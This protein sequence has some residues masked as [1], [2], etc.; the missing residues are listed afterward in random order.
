MEVRFTACHYSDPAHWS[1]ATL[2]GMSAV[3]T[4]APQLCK[5]AD[6]LQKMG[7]TSS[8]A[9]LSGVCCM[10]TSAALSKR[11]SPRTAKSRGGRPT[12]HAAFERD[13]R[14]LDAAAQLFL[15]RGYDATSIDSVAE[16]ARVSKPTVYSQY[17]DKRGLFEAV[18]KREI[19]RWL[20]PVAAAVQM[21]FGGR[22]NASLEKRLYDLG[23]QL[24]ALSNGAGARAVGRTL[25]AQSTNF[26]E[27]AELAYREGWEKTVANVAQLFDQLGDNGLAAIDTRIAA[28]MYLNVVIGQTTRLALHGLPIDIDAEEKR[29]R[30]SL[31]LLLKGI[32]Q[33]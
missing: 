2:P 17:H 8:F 20:A 9:P 18:L 25:A 33:T 22:A 3:A 12:K 10:V 7:L 23:R 28:E 5:E 16:T 24:I 11:A 14:L 4:T 1:C 31:K 26:P 15:E 30:A 13:L 21:K 29:L 32:Q 6:L 27:L 19:N